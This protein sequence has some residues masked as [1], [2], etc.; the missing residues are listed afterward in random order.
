MK[1]A[2]VA[3]TQQSTKKKWGKDTLVL[4]EGGGVVTAYL[5]ASAM[6]GMAAMTMVTRR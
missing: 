4:S 2:A 1:A 6:V 3:P 5:A